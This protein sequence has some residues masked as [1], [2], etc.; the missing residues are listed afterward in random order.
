MS[1]LAQVSQAMQF[2]LTTAADAAA[3]TSRFTRRVSKLSGA[4]FAQI[5]SFGW[6][7]NPDASYDELVHYAAV[8]GLDISAQGLAARFTP[9]AA[10]CLQSLLGTAVK[11]VIATQPNSLA[12][13]QRFTG[14]FAQD[15]TVLSL[16]AA[17]PR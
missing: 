4:L 12:L 3:R 10:A 14:V 6:W 1:T 5:V 2:V 13:L 15:G 16:P 17:Q 11:Q 7:D 8:R 9:E